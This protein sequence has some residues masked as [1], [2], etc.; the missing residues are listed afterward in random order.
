[1]G[2]LKP[3]SSSKKR[4]V[5]KNAEKLLSEK[6]ELNYGVDLARIGAMWSGILELDSPISPTEVA[7]MLSTV[8]L[9]RATTLVDAEE[10]WTMAAT[11]AALGAA[12]EPPPEQLED[13]EPVSE[14]TINPIGFTKPVDDSQQS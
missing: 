13:D 11:F 6:L 4:T 2:L 10:H 3:R 7:A 9:V 5:L 12:I 8:S 1:M 14:K